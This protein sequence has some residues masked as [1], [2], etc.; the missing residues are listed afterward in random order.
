MIIRC[1]PKDLDLAVPGSPQTLQAIMR[2]YPLPYAYAVNCNYFDPGGRPLGWLEER[3]NIWHMPQ[4]EDELWPRIDVPKAADGYGIRFSAGPYL[5]MDGVM[6][7]IDREIRHG[8]YTG[9]SAGYVT[10]QIAY[11]EWLDGTRG[12]IT[13]DSAS[14]V[15]LASH[16]LGAGATMVYKLDGGGSMGVVDDKRNLIAGH[17][18]RLL[19][20]ALVIRKAIEVTGVMEKCP[21]VAHKAR[22]GMWLADKFEEWEFRC[23]H[24]GQVLVNPKLVTLLQALRDRVGRAVIVNSGYRCPEH[25]AEVGGAA[26]SQ[27]LLGTAAD[28][29]VSGYSVDA[30]AKVAEQVG[31]TGIGR[32]YTQG[33]THVD[34]GPKRTWVG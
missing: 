30:L 32:Y 18:T 21:A 13:L 34:V 1:K 27:H 4:A 22:K 29:T 11:C 16:A 23:R 12:V 19:P 7:D 31:F 5:A 9:F 3:G 14:L 26:Q 20:C 6:L 17:G 25:N 33:F 2:G 10:Q 15:E 28:I 8:G 24:C